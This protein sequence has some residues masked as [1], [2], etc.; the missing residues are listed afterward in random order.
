VTSL[1]LLFAFICIIMQTCTCIIAD[2]LHAH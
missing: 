2:E 1:V